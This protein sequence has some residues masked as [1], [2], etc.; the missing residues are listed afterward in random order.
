MRW[1]Q[2]QAEINAFIDDLR[3]A[4]PDEPRAMVRDS[5]WR[6]IQELVGIRDLTTTKE[7]MHFSPCDRRCDPTGRSRE[8][9][10][11]H[12]GDGSGLNPYDLDDPRLA[13]EIPLAIVGIVPCKVSAEN[14]AIEAGDLLVTASIPGHA[15]KGTG[16]SR[17]IGAIVGKAL[18][19]LKQGTGIVLGLVT[20]Q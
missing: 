10:W 3:R 7:Y 12:A 6:A 11:R 9:A 20:L 13:A 15:M 5:R 8:H 19:P 17:M 2:G 16:R 14:G 4:S 18:E 1:I